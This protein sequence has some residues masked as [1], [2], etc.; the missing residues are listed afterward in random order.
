MLIG[1]TVLFGIFAELKKNM[2]FM[3]NCAERIVLS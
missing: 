1:P 3:E 2:I